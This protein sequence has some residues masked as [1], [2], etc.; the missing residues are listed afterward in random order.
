MS[1]EESLSWEFL[2][3]VADALDS[4]RIRALIDAKQ[5]ILDAG[6]YDETQ[7]ETILLKMFDEERLKYSLYNFFSNN[8][9]NNFSTIKEFSSQNSI[10]V[11]HTLS[12]LD[13]LK[14]EKLISVEELYDKIKAHEDDP[15]TLIFKDLSISITKEDISNLKSIYEPVIG[16]GSIVDTNN[17]SGCGLCHGICPMDC[18]KINNGFGE[19]DEKKCIRCG[20]CYFVCPRSYLPVKVLNMSLDTTSEIKEYSEIGYYIEIFSAKTKIKEISSVCQD[21]G[22]SS[23]CLYFLFEQ[24]RI[25]YALGAKTSDDPW[26]PEPFILK[27]KEDIISTAGTKYVNNPNLSLLNILNEKLPS[28]FDL[29]KFNFPF[30]INVKKPV[31]SKGRIQIKI[32]ILF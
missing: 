6:I 20:L 5:E 25:D 21:G 11:Y 4:Y 31:N 32:A 3:D 15:D 2:K 14:N 26:R 22:I 12:L 17:C 9:N 19:I 18:I 27:N 8:S 24:R 30:W 1:S 28:D 10:E 29:E 23:T 7:Y 16:N 13:L